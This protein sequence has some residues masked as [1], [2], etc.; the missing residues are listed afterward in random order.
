MRLQLTALLVVLGAAG[1][2]PAE[3]PSTCSPSNCLG[4]CDANGICNPGSTASACGF[5]GA[6]CS[7]CTAGL[8]CSAGACINAS[9]GGGGMTGGGGGA[10]GGGGGATGGG[11]GATGGGGGATGGG[12]GATGGGGGVTGGGGGATGGGGGATGGGSGALP[13]RLF[14]T[15]VSYVGD[16]GGLSGADAKCNTAARAANK[17]GTWTAW[18]SATSTSAPSRI[19]S[20]GPW[21]TEQTDGGVTLAFNNKANLSTTPL[22]ELDVDEEGRWTT[23]AYWTGTAGGGDPS[24]SR[25]A[26]WTTASNSSTGTFGTGSAA[27]STWTEAGASLCYSVRSLLCL[28]QSRTPPTPAGSAHKRVFVTS[29]QY[30]GN[31]GGLQGADM[32]CNTAAQAANRGGTWV[33]WLSTSS[34]PA[35]SRVTSNGPWYT[36]QADGGLTL[37]FRNSANLSTTPLSDLAVDETGRATTNAYWTGTRGGGEPSGSHCADWTAG[38][39]GTGTV[40]NGAAGGTTWTDNGTVYCYSTRALLCLEQ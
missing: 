22:A 34:I 31:L 37:A 15:S 30:T 11:G 10:T 16:L 5:G 3:Q 39:S 23:N 6:T 29:V 20:N 38:S 40:G 28:E 18:L 33:A 9:T 12:G 8:I 2:G 26:D 24:G 13:L 25:C 7:A 17:G 19:T 32:R 1:C 4:C 27:S 36:E 21:Y 14:V 35:P